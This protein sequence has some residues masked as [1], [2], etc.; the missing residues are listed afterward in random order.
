MSAVAVIVSLIPMFAVAAMRRTEA[1]ICRQLA[2][3]RAF[4][5][6]SSIQLSLSRSFDKRRLQGLIHGGAVRPTANGLHFLDTDGWGNYQRN[7][8]RRALLVLSVVV[9]LVGVVFAV[10]YVMR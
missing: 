6:E 4:T 10:A 1:R 8:R 2:D 5:A 3:A 9:A 7:R